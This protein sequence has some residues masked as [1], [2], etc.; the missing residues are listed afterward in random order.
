MSSPPFNSW[1][2]RLLEMAVTLVAVALL[3]NWTWQLVRPLLGVLVVAVVVY[4]WISWQ[5]QR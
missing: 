2:D 3:L 1:T 5:H 4:A